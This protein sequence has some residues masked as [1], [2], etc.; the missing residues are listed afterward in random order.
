MVMLKA[1][2]E[3]DNDIK[4][5]MLY[6]IVDKSIKIYGWKPLLLFTHLYLHVF[7]D[8]QSLFSDI[9]SLKILFAYV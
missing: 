8:S 2:D 9:K 7:H 4:G 5:Y 1:V 6:I 3:C